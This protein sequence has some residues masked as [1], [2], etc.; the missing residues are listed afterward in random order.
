MN[1]ETHRMTPE[2]VAA[3]KQSTEGEFLVKD[4]VSGHEHWVPAELVSEEDRS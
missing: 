4:P 2:E 1:I 3:M